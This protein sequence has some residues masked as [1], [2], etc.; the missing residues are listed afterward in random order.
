MKKIIKEYLKEYVSGIIKENEKIYYA[1]DQFRNDETK[2]KLCRKIYSQ[3]SWLYE[4][5]KLG[6]Q[7]II[8]EILKPIK[9]PSTKDQIKKLRSG[10][11]ILV[12]IGKISKGRQYYLIK[13]I[14][15][16]KGSVL[17]NGKWAPVNKLNTNTADLA[18]LITD[19]LYKSPKAQ[20]IIQK[21]IE[22]P[23]D[24]LTTIQP[25]LKQLL[26]KYFQNPESFF[27]YVKNIEFRSERGGKAEENVKK[28]FENL[29]FKTEY[30]GGDGDFID[31]IF[32]IDLIMSS[33]EY[34]VKTI[35][36]KLDEN[37]WDRN[38][39]YKFVDWV[40]ISTPFTIYENKTKDIVEL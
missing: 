25:K 22:D 32:G 17:I 26:A 20:P 15:E 39:E 30:Q 16:N 34:G 19:L 8:D 5:D 2:R 21:I 6:L 40:V 29:G 14:I 18:E 11:D 10:T 37:A 1:C 7:P 12:K 33:D 3:G 27:D 23:K 24:G 36:V 35:Q 13:D 31:M 38:K 9:K 4:A 28:T